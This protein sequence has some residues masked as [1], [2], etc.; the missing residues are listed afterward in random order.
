VLQ[1]A[2]K[3][4]LTHRVD[5]METTHLT[6]HL[7][8]VI[9]GVVDTGR[10]D[11]MAYRTHHVEQPLTCLM[12]LRDLR[13]PPATHWDPTGLVHTVAVVLPALLDEL[14]H[15]VAV[16]TA[17]VLWVVSVPTPPLDLLVTEKSKAAHH[18]G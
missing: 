10:P 16:L 9:H 1:P 8:H 7:V 14:P 5:P 17:P 3:F 13:V 6:H 4:S 2:K 18:S 15:T 11:R 12:L